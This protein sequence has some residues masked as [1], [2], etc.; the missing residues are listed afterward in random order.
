MAKPYRNPFTEFRKDLLRSQRERT[1][2]RMIFNLGPSGT[3]SGEAAGQIDTQGNLVEYA[4]FDLGEWDR[5]LF[6]D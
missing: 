1:T 6:G 3:G 2:G 5:G 4:Q